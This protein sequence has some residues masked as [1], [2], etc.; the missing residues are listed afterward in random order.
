M[1]QTE[2]PVTALRV[3]V[4]S[5]AEAENHL[6]GSIC[7]VALDD[8]YPFNGGPEFLLLIDHLL[9]KIGK[10]QAS[11]LTRSFSGTGEG[12][13]KQMNN[14]SATYCGDPVRYRSSEDIAAQ[15]GKRST[16]D[17]YFTSRQKSSWQ[18]FVKNEDGV[19]VGSFKSDVDFINLLRNHK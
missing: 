16:F 8:T 3:C 17:I 5:A 19:T 4:D 7:G 2:Y 14:G 10:P 9:D 6:S 11:R 12:S 15:H 13:G 18:G 1:K